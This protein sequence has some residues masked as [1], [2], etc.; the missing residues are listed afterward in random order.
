MRQYWRQAASYPDAENT[1]LAARLLRRTMNSG[2][3]VA[4]EPDHIV[5]AVAEVRIFSKLRS[6]ILIFI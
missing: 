6:D 1:T 3:L 5:W 4:V 2:N